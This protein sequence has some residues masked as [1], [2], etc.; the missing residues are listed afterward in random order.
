MNYKYFE[1]EVS[2]GLGKLTEIDNS[3]HPP[4]IKKLH[5]VFDGWLEN[6]ILETFPCFLVSEGLKSEIE[7]NNLSGIS[8]SDLTITFSDTFKQIYGDKKMP[9]FYWAKI[10]GI[11]G[12]DDF[13]IEL[14]NFKLVISPTAY[15]LLLSFNISEADVEDYNTN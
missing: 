14:K 8:F 9:K 3:V 6:D 10:S 5:F 2:G 1:P 12:L 11:A 4:L 7:V 13:G 15:T